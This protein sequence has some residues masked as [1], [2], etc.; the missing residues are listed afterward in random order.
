MHFLVLRE[1]AWGPGKVSFIERCFLYRGVCPCIVRVYQ[2]FHHIN[3]IVANGLTI[4]RVIQNFHPVIFLNADAII[5]KFAPACVGL[6][7]IIL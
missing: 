2:S 1:L 5:L 4:I 7:Y 3:S 6:V